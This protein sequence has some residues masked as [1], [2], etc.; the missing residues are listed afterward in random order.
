[1]NEH[2]KKFGERYR[3]L[4]EEG[5]SIRAELK[6][7]LAKLVRFGKKCRALYEKG[8]NDRRLYKPDPHPLF[9]KDEFI[10]DGWNYEALLRLHDFDY[11][12]FVESAEDV[13]TLLFNLVHTPFVKRTCKGKKQENQ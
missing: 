4:Q 9:H 13:D 1:M 11:Y 2:V 7:L 3:A 6:P 8:D 10:E 12:D 5:K